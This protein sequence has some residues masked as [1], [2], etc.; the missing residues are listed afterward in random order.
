MP[1]LPGRSGQWALWPCGEDIRLGS[2]TRAVQ[3]GGRAAQVALGM[4]TR[5]FLVG[6]AQAH[7]G[8]G[9]LGS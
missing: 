2:S 6:S 4:S 5:G 7:V 1:T 3:P 9:S 8:V